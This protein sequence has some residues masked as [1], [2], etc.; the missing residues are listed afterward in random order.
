ME[1]LYLDANGRVCVGVS[2]VLTSLEEALTISFVNRQGLKAGAAE[3]TADF[4]AIKPLTPGRIP[5]FYKRH[6]ELTLPPS[7][8]DRLTNE[9]L[10][11]YYCDLGAM[12]PGFDAFP[13]D[14]KLALCDMIFSMG[15][16]DLSD[17]ITFNECVRAQNW[18]KAAL[19]SARGFP[20]TAVRNIYVQGLFE[21]AHRA[22]KTAAVAEA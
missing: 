9:S 15:A 6:V 17:W 5:S 16:A 1:H 19:D 8:I 11:Q 21:R 18:Q 22:S 10:A 3:I 7:E 20:V 4:E 14:A 12:Y 13:S 2:H